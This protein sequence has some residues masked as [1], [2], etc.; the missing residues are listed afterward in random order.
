M[1]QTCQPGWAFRQIAWRSASAVWIADGA[2][3]KSRIA[4]DRP[5][6]IV[7]DDGQPG[8]L[9]ACPRHPSRRCRARCDRP[10]R[11]RWAP[12][13]RCDGRGRR[14]RCKPST[15]REPAS[16]APGS[17]CTDHHVDG[18]VTRDRFAEPG[19]D[20]RG[21]AVH[22]RGRQVRPVQASPSMNCWRV[23]DISRVS[24]SLR[25]PAAEPS[26]S[27]LAV[28]GG[29]TAHRSARPVCVPGQSGR[30]VRPLPGKDG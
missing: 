18:P 22:G 8:L 11:W 15:P 12:R 20:E 13:P 23:G 4:G 26:Q 5:A 30:G 9:A 1:P 10:A 25:D 27:E 28:V 2:P 14:R 6:V 19:R 16:P 3:K 29:P 24:R 7:E 21:L 17:R